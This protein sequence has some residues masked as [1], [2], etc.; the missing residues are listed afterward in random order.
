MKFAFPQDPTHAVS[1]IRR[2][3]ESTDAATQQSNLE[4]KQDIA[5]VGETVPMLF[6]RRHN[7]GNGQGTNGGV[8]ISP[9]LI[10]LGIKQN[11]LSM[12]YLLSQGN[13]SG[14]SINN[15]YWGYDKLRSK[16]SGS[17]FCS[18]Y[19]GVPSCLDL[20]YNPGGSISWTTTV[21]KNGPSGT[22]SFTTEAN[23]Q[24]IVIN[25]Q[26]TISISGSGTIVGGFG[27][28]YGVIYE[29]G[30][31]AGYSGGSIRC[32][33]T[34]DS[35]NHHPPTDGRRW[36]PSGS[37]PHDELKRMYD[38]P[39]TWE[40]NMDFND[41]YGCRH[42]KRVKEFDMS[43]HHRQASWSQTSEV[44]ISY[45]VYNAATNALV[46]SGTKWVRHG[47]SS[48]TIS[49]LSPASYRVTFSDL[50]KERNKA[51]ATASISTPSTV[52]QFRERYM[53][54]YPTR[55]PSNGFF[56]HTNPGS[57]TQNIRSTVT[58]TIY[59]R[60]DFP[61]LPG[62]DNQ[63]VGGLSDLTM[64]GIRGAIS[65]LRP[66]DGPDYFLQAHLFASQGISVRRVLGGS[67][68]SALYSD[69]VYHLMGMS[70][71][72]QSD[73][74]DFGSL[75]VAARMNE[76]YSLFFNGV[77][78]TTN[79]LA[80]WMTRTAPYFLLTPRQINGK[81]GL[82][83]V[84]PLDS[85][86]YLSRSPISPSIVIDEDDI[87]PGSYN[88]RYIANK[89][90]RPV[91]LVM[92]YRDQPTNTVGQT[93]TVEVRYPGTALSGPFEQH[94]LT[95]F[96][97][98]SEHCVYAA[99]YILAKRRYTTHTCTLAISRRGRMINPGDIVRV[100]LSLNT[101]DGNGITD[102]IMYQVESVSEGQRGTV[103][104]ELM[105]FPVDSRNVSII[106]KEVHSGRVSIQ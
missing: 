15:V 76:R 51:Y 101:S 14:L 11:D 9:R 63:L 5:T 102:S 1:A 96:C 61:D 20:D 54:S 22:G 78:Q 83:P 60:I 47:S 77:L 94:D 43:K 7:F 103:S 41:S 74:I 104:L 29:G 90:R 40:A 24:K 30:Y 69:L 26:S 48:L 58:Q 55:G 91:C 92:V 86:N 97:C 75:Q 46:T 65:R 3:D 85:S 53:A 42:W 70:K 18:A 44:R 99:R 31:T 57:E 105:H 80:E 4:R 95:E 39:P 19:Q 98:R 17:Q 10:Q 59:N 81:Y 89:D 82:A 50:Y 25:W 49:G 84:T 45:Y 35:Y 38:C 34:G 67:G 73:Q 27:K 79:S 52:D 93:V 72:L 8:W 16:D 106:A 56:R 6:C 13:V 28:T 68:P 33:R 87:I 66:A 12:M 32:I 21:Q 64:I 37:T 88:R 23:C 100:N 71:L 2:Y 62:G 36:M